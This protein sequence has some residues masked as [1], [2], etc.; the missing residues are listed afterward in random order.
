MRAVAVAGVLLLVSTLAVVLWQQRGGE[1]EPVQVS[2]GT[3]PRGGVYDAYGRGLA[4]F[5]AT[6]PTQINAQVTAASVANIQMVHTGEL[7]AG[8]TLADVAALAVEGAEPFGQPQ[9]IRAIARLYDNHVHLVVRADADYATVADLARQ[10]V[11]VGAA[12]SGTEMVA[13]RLLDLGGVADGA[14]AVMIHQ[15]DLE[16]SA[17]ALE[18]GTIEA[19]FWSGGLPT[20]AITDLEQRTGIRLIDLA[21]FL[22]DLSER[23][24]PYFIDAPIPIGTY[25]QVPSVRTIGVPSMLIVRADLPDQVAYELTLMLIESRDDLAAIHPVA[26]HLSARSAIATLP[27]ELH[28]GAAEYFRQSKYAYEPVSPSAAAARPPSPQGRAVAGS[29]RR[30][31]G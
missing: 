29:A 15:L 16:D 30:P 28:P 1:D 21:A 12:D 8:F 4:E 26:L 24:G 3:G 5:S 17:R 25:G 10:P 11:S 6:Q 9:E 23:Y 22:P 13:G 2:L 7:D 18:D 14:D 27:V 20:A 31:A 19:F